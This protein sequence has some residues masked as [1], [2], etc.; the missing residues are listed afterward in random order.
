[1]AMVSCGIAPGGFLDCDLFDHDVLSG[2]SSMPN[3]AA[4]EGLW[5]GGGGMREWEGGRLLC[6]VLGRGIGISR[7]TETPVG[8]RPGRWIAIRCGFGC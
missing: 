3:Y 1:M 7:A 5:L 4:P 8:Q 6:G 2:G